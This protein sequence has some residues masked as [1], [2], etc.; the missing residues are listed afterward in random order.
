MPWFVAIPLG[1]APGALWLWFLWTKDDHEPEPPLAVLGVFA[2]GCASAF[3]TLSLRPWL[4]PLIPWEPEWWMHAF[5]AFV[6]TA[7][8]EEFLKISAC[9]VFLTW[10]REVDEPLDGLLYGA[11]A[12]LGFA[13][14]ENAL[15]VLRTSEA[16][17][18]LMRGFTATLVHATC[19]GLIGLALVSARLCGKHTLRWVL[20]ALGLAI[21]L[22]GTYD[23]FLIRDDGRAWVSLLAALPL[24]TVM[25]SVKTRWA[26]AKSA[27]FHP[28]PPTTAS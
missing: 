3:A 12:G 11:A 10:H 22:H 16:S 26:R 9:A 24:M 1:L 4:E 28:R 18:A 13:S 21:A 25:L 7:G 14:F 19:T 6:V 5:D 23:Y 27:A 8:V 2:L 17:L 15:Y 20:G